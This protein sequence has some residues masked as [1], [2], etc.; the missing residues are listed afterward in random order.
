MDA[1]VV[2]IGAGPAG[3]ATAACLMRRGVD[4][5]VLDRGRAVGDSWRW[6]YDRLHLHTPRIQSSLPGF[7]IPRGFGRW[8]A[9]DDVVA[10]LEEYA[11]HHHIAPRFGVEVRRLEHQG[12]GWRI[13]TSD[14]YL[15]SAQVV[16]AT[17]YSHTP[18]I[19]AWPGLEQ[20]SGRF[21]HA[22]EYQKPEPFFGQDVLVVGTGNTGAEIATDLAERGAARVWLSVRTPP[23]VVPRSMIGI[24]TLMLAATQERAPVWLADPVNR[25]LQRLFIGDLTPTGMPAPRQGVVAQFRAS[26]VVPIIDVGLVQQLRAG[27]VTPVGAVQAFTPSHVVLADERT[28]KPDVVIAATGYHRGLE[29]LVG[30]LGILDPDGRPTV[31]G[32]RTHPSAPG[33]RFIGLTNPQKGLLLQIRLDAR[34]VARAIAR[35]LGDTRRR[36]RSPGVISASAHRSRL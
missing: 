12:D 33:L 34:A 28:I 18:V 16:I 30:H 15:G 1:V 8:V 14:G 21:L 5:L 23:N 11:R 17:G 3:L 36:L 2:V 27:G 22:R 10:Y 25:L 35:E 19:P 7:P 29:P 26:D 6:R 13:S 32:S 20:W 4:C 9:R 31:R 24:P